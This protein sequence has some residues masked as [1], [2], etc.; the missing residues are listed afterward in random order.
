[1]KKALIVLMLLMSFNANAGILLL[2][3]CT[4]G[5]NPDYGQ[6]GY[7][8]YYKSYTGG[9]YSFWFRSYCPQTYTL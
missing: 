6:S 9:I 3:S 2:Q 7:T 5:F 4:F 1:M 8:G